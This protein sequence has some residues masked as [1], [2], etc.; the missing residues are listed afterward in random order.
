MIH[1]KI[2]SI[3]LVLIFGLTLFTFPLS[4]LAADKIPENTIPDSVSDIT[5]PAQ[6][7]SSNPDFASGVTSNTILYNRSLLASGGEISGGCSITMKSTT[8][9]TIEGHSEYTVSDPALRIT[10][11]L[12]AYYNGAWHTLATTTKAISGTSV[13]LSQGYT[14]T[15]GYYYRTYARHS[16]ADGASKT[17]Y[18]SSIYVG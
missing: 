17:S 8:S 9:V 1:K 4:S 15:S 3:T 7:I 5:P 14:V 2:R 12:Q 13:S 10:L 6:D 11:H 18:T 16:T